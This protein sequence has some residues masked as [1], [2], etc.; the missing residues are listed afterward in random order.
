MPKPW[1]KLWS[2][3]LDKE[4]I[5]L[6]SGDQFKAWVNMLAVAL[7]HDRDGEL[8]ELPS[9]AFQTRMTVAAV[10]ETLDDLVAAGVFERRRNRYAAHD[11]KHWQGDGMSD[12]QR[13]AKQRA[14]SR[15]MS[16]DTNGDGHVTESDMSHGVSRARGRAET[17]TRQD[18]DN[19]PPNPRKRGK[20]SAE[21]AEPLVLP[22]WVPREEWLDFQE[23]RRT[24]SKVKN[25]ITLAVALKELTRLR[26]LGNDPAAVLR[27]STMSGWA[28][29]FELPTSTAKPN[30]KAAHHPTDVVPDPRSPEQ[31]KIDDD[32][33]DRI[34]AA[35]KAKTS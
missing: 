28:G 11:W 21:P 26:E 6:L 25:P 19:I 24:H 12:A 22:D 33:Y 31:I 1:L 14:M 30:G 18:K 7:R 15:D 4:K 35:R 29:L 13:K 34:L 5:Q 3:I 23:M 32:N 27:R 2:N 9:V 17:K 16:R 20:R 8:P 10:T